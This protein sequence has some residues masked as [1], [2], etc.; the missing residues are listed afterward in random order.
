MKKI[1]GYYGITIVS[2]LT[3][4]VLFTFLFG[5]A[6]ENRQ[7]LQ[8]I[9]GTVMEAQLNTFTRAIRVGDAFDCIAAHTL[10]SISLK[11]TDSLVKGKC[12][13]L[14]QF[15][16]ALD[17]SGKSVSTCVEGVWNEELK[18]DTSVQ[19]SGTNNLL[20]TNAGVYWI[21]ISA[22]DA[23]GYQKNCMMKIYVKEG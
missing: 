1:F 14:T 5:N 4:L 10:P 20:F 9:L 21:E 18:V 22:R 12:I 13:P 2:V 17:A 6:F 11:N 15:V 16:T 7:N 8:Q 3:A 23:Q 19:L